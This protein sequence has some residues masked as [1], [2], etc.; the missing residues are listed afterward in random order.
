[1]SRRTGRT[2]VR[3]PRPQTSPPAAR[4]HRSVRPL[5]GLLAV[6]LLL[7][8]VLAGRLFDLQVVNHEQLAVQAAD[9]STRVVTEPALRGR[10]LAADGTLLVANAPTTVV[11]VDPRVLLESDDEGRAL[12][13]QVA[14]ELDLP[15]E[16][17][18]GRT[19]LCGTEGAPPVPSCFSGSPYQPI[20]IAFDVDPVAA[21]A[22]LERPERFPGIAIDTRP[23]RTYPETSVNAAHLLGYLGRPTQ[24]EVSARDD[25]AA[26]DLLGRAGLEAT[27]DAQLR[28]TSGRTTV[29]I[30]PR[31][32]VTGQLDHSDPVSG[33]DLVTHLDADLQ[34]EVERTL[35]GTVRISRAQGWPAESAAA[36]VLDVRT[37][38]VVAAASH[39]TYDPSIWTTGV[40]QAQYDALTSDA[41]GQPLVNR[42]VSET[43]PPASTFKVISLPAA[44]ATGVDP[45]Q[46]YAC[47]GAVDIGG[48]RFTNYESRAHG[49]LSLQRIMEVSC[50]TVFYGWAYDE[51]RA[52]GGLAQESDLTDPWVITSEQFGLGQRTG[53]DLPGE[54]SGVVPGREW[55][56]AYWEA[57]REDSCARAE[58][59]YPEE[60][61]QE[62]REFLEQL[63]RENCADGWQYR[64]GDAVNFS[65]GQGDVAVTP[66]QLAVVYAAIA[67]GGT[68]WEPQVV[69]E[70]RTPAGELV[71]DLAPVASGEVGLEPEVLE[72]VRSGLAGVNTNGTGVPA[73]ATFDLEAYPVAG[74]TGSAE[75]F[76]ERST[77]WYAS[78]GPTTDPQYA[79][80]VV[81]EQGGIGGDIAAP[82]ARRI[83]D[84]IAGQ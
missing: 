53:V 45:D 9:V 40:T 62:R 80:V 52:Q 36:V 38:G 42:V 37:G 72:I 32:V 14:L 46:E 5:W 7:G 69:D 74:K 71:D 49:P 83:W 64:P 23:V 12:I 79:V 1:M 31:G 50:D 16:S 60:T 81:I 43:F 58:T 28:G 25:L 61:D 8:T 3:V 15:V 57:T 34:A 68:L 39:P 4:R 67:N 18:W 35:A 17:L 65:I 27:Y 22:V 75:S 66:L 48:R 59:G 44:L 24:E 56:R 47:P 21:L 55:K 13:E 26:E 19:R 70:V 73:F 76:G 51:W 54:T 6:A 11:T 82:A 10:I 29:T 63:A 2:Q 77:A 84:A 30:D 41:S 78:Y 33:H 20:P